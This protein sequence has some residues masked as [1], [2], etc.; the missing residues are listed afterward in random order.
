MV[1]IKYSL[2]AENRF[3]YLLWQL[4]PKV[5]K[6][7]EWITHLPTK[8]YVRHYVTRRFYWGWGDCRGWGWALTTLL[9]LPWRVVPG[10]KLLW[11][12]RATG[13]V[14]LVP[15][16]WYI[17]V[18][19]PTEIITTKCSSKVK[20]G[21]AQKV[22][23]CF[24]QNYIITTLTIKRRIKNI[25]FPCLAFSFAKQESK[26][27]WNLL[28]KC[29]DYWLQNFLWITN[30]IVFFWGG[31]TGTRL[32]RGACAPSPGD[33]TGGVTSPIPPIATA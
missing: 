1:S 4:W 15:Y 6:S 5:S 30:R 3:G 20:F 28:L 18:L 22:N 27:T 32:S 8:S 13:I 29:Y 26:K 16:Y 23:F 10:A 33:A 25:V 2:F 12:Y 7:V 31:G 9:E 17:I 21:Y 24:L 14:W 11:G 19:L